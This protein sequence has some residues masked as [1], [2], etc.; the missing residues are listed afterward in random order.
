AYAEIVAKAKTPVFFL[1]MSAQTGPS[2]VWYVSPYES[3]ATMEATDKALSAEKPINDELDKLSEQDG[4]Y[5]SKVSA[6][7]AVYHDEMSYRP[8]VRLGEMRYFNVLTFHVKP[9]RENDFVEGSKAIVASHEKA[10]MDEH[11]VTYQVVSGAPS[12]TFL[13]FI[14]MK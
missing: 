1:A 5:V 13:V 11:W 12:G 14:P 8:K 3:F 7:L 2:E 9:G 10:N 6:M 4:E